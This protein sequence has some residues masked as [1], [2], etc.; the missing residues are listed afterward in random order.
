MEDSCL[1]NVDVAGSSSHDGRSQCNER[2]RGG[3]PV[4]RRHTFE[5]RALFVFTTARREHCGRELDVTHFGAA[6]GV[7]LCFLTRI[8][9][10]L[11]R[12]AE[13]KPLAHDGDEYA[14][15]KAPLHYVW[16]VRLWILA[17][18]RE[19]CARTAQI[20]SAR[21]GRGK[22]QRWT[23]AASMA[24]LSGGFNT[25]NSGRATP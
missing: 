10:V 21:T 4:D 13:G 12:G 14:A 24:S 3:C 2:A 23:T 11:L 22:G 20:P 8:A 25:T 6:P 1:G 7:G 16:G 17:Y 19:I 15:R 9:D 5:A 18:V